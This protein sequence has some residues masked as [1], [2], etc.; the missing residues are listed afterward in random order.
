[1]TDHADSTHDRMFVASVTPWTAEGTLDEPAFRDLLRYFISASEGVDDFAIIVNPEAG[2][3][4][5]CDEDEQAKVV[6]VALN[7]VAGRLPLWTGLLANSTKDTVALARR[8]SAIEVNGHRVGGLF[9]MPPIGALDV[10][11][12]WDASRYPEVWQDMLAD[13]AHALPDTPLICHPVA[14]P[15]PKF[16]VGLPL[17]ATLSILN[18][19]PQVVGWKMTYNYEGFRIVSRALRGLDRHVGILAATAVNFH[20]NLAS[21]TFDG[22][23]TG[24]FNYAL[25]PMLE[26]IQAWRE[27]DSAK[28]TELWGQGLAELHEYVYSE[29]GRL[30][31]RYKAATWLHGAI[32][33]PWMRAP[34]P[35]P[36]KDEILTLRDLYARAGY[37][38]I[39]QDRIDEVLTQLPR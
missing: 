6:E 32:P 23:V 26:H 36:R 27:G 1:V 17:D 33:T 29:W 15:S 5:Y 38:V 30:H 35:K 34:F 9:V 21:D 16:G 7:E 20:E 31:V 3:V 39:D 2:E 28:A 13:I 12:G 37:T 18:A 8:L 10:T 19:V 14:A 25:E 22:T 11:I 24:S 4:F